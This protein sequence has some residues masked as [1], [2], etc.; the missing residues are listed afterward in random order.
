MLIEEIQFWQWPLGIMQKNTG[1]I[2]LQSL[3]EI[4]RLVYKYCFSE[5]EEQESGEGWKSPGLPS[6]ASTPPPPAAAAVLASKVNRQ[7]WWWH[8]GTQRCPV[9]QRKLSSSNFL[10]P[11]PAG[12]SSESTPFFNPSVPFGSA[13]QRTLATLCWNLFLHS[14]SLW[15]DWMPLKDSLNSTSFA[16]HQGDSK[17]FN[18]SASV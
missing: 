5:R 6:P 13:P 3:M 10:L 18:V 17:L 12:Q 1:W 11:S 4:G 15:L 14:W 2:E 7:L 16:W 9:R 8:R